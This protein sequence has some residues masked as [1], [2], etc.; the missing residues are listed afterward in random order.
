MPFFLIPEKY[1]LTSLAGKFDLQTLV[2]VFL[3]VFLVKQHV[4]AIVRD[5]LVM[6]VVALLNMI[7][8]DAPHFILLAMWALKLDEGAL[9]FMLFY[10][11]CGTL[12]ATV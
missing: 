12:I 4:T 2:L 10:F 9:A 3:Q 1:F 5:A 8:E 7:D 6:F 11:V